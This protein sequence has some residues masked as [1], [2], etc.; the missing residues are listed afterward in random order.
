ML[1]ALLQAA[2]GESG[3]DVVEVLLDLL[4]VLLAAK[5]G[6]ELAD[7]VGAPTVVGEILAG[8]LVGPSALGLIGHD[9]VLPV[10]AEIGVI[11]LLLE[12]GLE[13]DLGELAKVGRS[14]M[15][16]AVTGVVL[17]F[18]AGYG[19]MRA[20]GESGNTALFIGAALTATSVGITARVFGDLRALATS[21]A[22][23]V[24]GAAVADDVLGLVILTVVVRVVTEGSVSIVSVL[25]IVV[26]AVLFLV[27]GG[28]VASVLAP[29]IFAKVQKHSHSSGTVLVI[30]IVFTLAMAE[31]ADASKLAPIVGAFVAGLALTRTRQAE[32]IRR[33]LA[34]VSHVFV[35]VFFVL[36][37]LDTDV[38]QFAQPSVLVLAAVLTLVGV[39]GKIAAGWAASGPGDR[40]LIGL[41]MIPRGEVGLIFAGIGLREGVLGEKLYAALLL[42]VLV[43]TL[44]TPPLLSRRFGRIQRR[45]AS[46][47]D[48][49]DPPP[50]GWLRIEAELVDLAAIP[51]SDLALPIGLRTA[52]LVI[53]RTPSAALL[54][55]VSSLPDDAFA[56]NPSATKLLTELLRTGNERSWRFL[57]TTGFLERALP[58]LATS[59]ERRRRDP[60]HLEPNAI[61]RWPTV[62]AV[63]LEL[64]GIDAESPDAVRLNHPELLVFAALL[65]D[66]TAGDANE[67][68]TTAALLTRLA[69]PA[70]QAAEIRL[71]VE[72][73]H[74]LAA[75]AR[76]HD[77]LDEAIITPLA[78]HLR[79]REQANALFVLTTALGE[80]EPVSLLRLAEIRRFIIETIDDLSE[81]W[82]HLLDVLEVRRQGAKA[83]LRG[84]RAADRVDAAPRSWLLTNRP[85]ELAAQAEMLD[86][87][88]DAHDVRIVVEAS[89]Q[90]VFVSRDRVGLLAAI[91]AAL[92][93]S[94]LDI[95]AARAA[96]WADGAA[97]SVF[98]HASGSHVDIEELRREALAAFDDAPPARPIVEFTMSFDQL[99]SPW[100]TIVSVSADDGPGLLHSVS[101]AIASAGLRIHSARIDTLGVAVRDTFE[102]TDARGAK[103]SGGDEQRVRA[104]LARGLGA[105]DSSPRRFWTRPRPSLTGSAESRAHDS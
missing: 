66:V 45:R 29:V 28:F 101:S 68:E 50:G 44:A 26:I 12:V 63:Q 91:T 34:P 57:L 35:P 77:G 24:L 43:T 10:L 61:M 85:E 1:S 37:G 9:Q 4:I 27:G 89:G 105:T 5:A 94:G 38:A 83:L 39:I 71:L 102:V 51:P 104:A 54:D 42:V 98:S 69:L 56:W 8:I 62:Q 13:M 86:P 81:G 95:E 46:P 55:W 79:T 16:V 3:I 93:R 19:V 72:E 36:I 59:I 67:P 80:L 21:E 65:I 92:E 14:S 17:P 99:A 30:A 6:A 20:F 88:P 32:R 53:T 41:G 31:L 33:D 76:R 25:G 52:E 96:T 70:D 23:T 103:V 64:A 11:L 100:Y 84:G 97:L 60:S 40:Q 74:L 18:A 87:I 90:I 78:V 22:R 73:T 47:S 7:R 15:Q 2:T 75:A 49:A 82:P 58:E 48:Q